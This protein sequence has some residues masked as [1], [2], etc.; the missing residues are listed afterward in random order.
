M[1]QT[2][3]ILEKSYKFGVVGSKIG[4]NTINKLQHAR[5]LP[6]KELHKLIKLY[7]Q[8]IFL[9]SNHIQGRPGWPSLWGGGGGS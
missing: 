2:F 4:G 7:G 6:I 5:F 9:I 1:S 8:D 3:P